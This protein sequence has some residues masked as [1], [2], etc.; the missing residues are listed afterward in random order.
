MRKVLI[1]NRG[2]IAIRVIRTARELGLGTVAVYSDAD[3]TGLHVRMA[4]EAFHIGASPSRESYLR[5]ERIL[6]VAKKTGAEFIHPGYGFLSEN[7][8]FARA[9]VDAG[10]T[11]VGPPASAMD[12]MGEKTAARRKMIEAGVPVVTGTKDPIADVQEAL[13][14]AKSIGFPVMLKAAAGGGGKGMRRIDREEDFVKSFEA[15][16]REAVSSFGDGRVYLEKFLNK[17][18]HIEIQVFADT[19]G[20]T[21]HLHERECSV[22]RRQQKVIEESPSPL[23]DPDMRA[24]MG[25]M[26]V[27]AAAAVG[28]VGAGTI[29]CLA[30]ADRNFYFL[31]MNTRLQVEHPVTEMVTGQDLVRWQLQVAMGETL[32]LAQHEIPLLGHAIEARVYAEDPDRN[33]MPA[34]GLITALREPGG[35]YVRNDCGVYAGF[36]VPLFYDPMISKLVVWHRTRTE[37]I[38]RMKRA[39]GEYV[40]DGIVTNIPYLRR[41]LDLPEFRAGDYDTSLLP[42]NHER[43]TGHGANLTAAQQDAALVAAALARQ[44][45]DDADRARVSTGGGAV[46]DGSEWKRA[47]RAATLRRSEV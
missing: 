7:A 35:P 41:V 44:S 16:Q 8:T 40:V 23:L 15:A 9:C 3:R 28:Y 17:P 20:N 14:V 29:E 30:D 19:H 47:G 12:A 33:F 18:R 31:E 45:R 27:K 42:K 4:D 39:L 36:T 5:M 21:V 1:A 6:D 46:S 25:A 24:K 2:E 32:P 43:L 34:P 13:S 11:F 37:A 10:V 22:Q 38:E 26:A